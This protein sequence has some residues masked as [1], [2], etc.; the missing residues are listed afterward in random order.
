MALTAQSA[1]AALHFRIHDPSMAG[2]ARR[3]VVRLAAALGFDEPTAGRAALI[4]TELATNLARHAK[5]G[6]LAVRPLGDTRTPGIEIVA[7]DRGPG[8]ANVARATAD[9]YSTAGSPGSGLGAVR[10]LATRF[11]IF[12]TPARG[13]VVFTELWPGAPA[14]SRFE[15]GVI[16]SAHPDEASSGDAWAMRPR[17]RG[18]SVAIVDGLGH[19]L[20]AA[21]AAAE[22]VQLFRGQCSAPAEALE[23]MHRGMAHTRGAAVAIASIDVDTRELRWAS[24]GNVAATIFAPDDERHLVGHDGTIGHSVRKIDERVY[25]WRAR[26]VLVAHTDGVGRADLTRY[27]GIL[28][29][30][31]AVLAAAVYV[32]ARRPRDD[33]TVVALRET[34]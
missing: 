15:L 33:A 13:T 20:G 7:L 27:P 2:E 5:G 28:G 6:E 31:P 1:H 23:K 17:A 14:P 19:G 11:D 24:I 25:P 34:A 32:D 12:S 21:L 22:A 18:I 4:V 16:S 3:R 29:R 9:G 10:R 30:H 8:I 26:S